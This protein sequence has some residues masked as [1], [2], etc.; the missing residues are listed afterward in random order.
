[1]A[2]QERFL[3]STISQENK[4]T[5]GSNPHIKEAGKMKDK[6]IAERSKSLERQIASKRDMHLMLFIDQL[7]KGKKTKIFVYEKVVEVFIEK[8]YRELDRIIII[9]RGVESG[10]Q[11]RNYHTDLVLFDTNY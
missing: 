9:S 10:T 6:L 1:M 5:K 4:Q 2:M 11:H 8:V 7:P 3:K